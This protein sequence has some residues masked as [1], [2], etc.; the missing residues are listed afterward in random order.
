[1]TLLFV[2]KPGE[3]VATDNSDATDFNIF[4]SYARKAF[5]GLALV[6][7]KAKRCQTGSVVLVVEYDIL[8]A[9]TCTVLTR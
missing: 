6:I 9:I 1:V 7:I 2:G 5:N 4:S 3:I 8:H